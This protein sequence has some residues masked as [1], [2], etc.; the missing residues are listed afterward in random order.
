[1]PEPYSY[2][3]TSA[4][5]TPAALTGLTVTADLDAIALVGACTAS[6]D[7]YHYEY[8]WEAQ[9]GDDPWTEI[10]RTTLPTFTHYFANLN[11][12]VRMRVSDSNGALYS[13]PTESVGTLTFSRWTLAHATGNADYIMPLAW[14]QEGATIDLPLD[15]VAIQPLSGPNGDTQLPIVFTGQWQGER[16]SLDVLVPSDDQSVLEALKG[17]VLQAAGSVAIKSPDGEVYIVQIGP[18]RL[19]KQDGFTLVSVSAIR[20]A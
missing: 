3:W 19:T 1:M 15:Q 5:A 14:A 16:V 8:L 17:A 4:F 13:T 12:P 6:A 10:G 9:V 7:T 2:A 11:L 20:V 18:L